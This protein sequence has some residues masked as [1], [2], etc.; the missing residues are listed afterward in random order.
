ML[1]L[2]E[3]VVFHFEIRSNNKIDSK[4]CIAIHHIEVEV[5][6]YDAK[7]NHFKVVDLQARL[8]NINRVQ[9]RKENDM[10]TIKPIEGRTVRISLGL[11]L[12]I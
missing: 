12:T 10:A 8:P 7:T 3:H 4:I 5:T 11:Q 1:L 6:F 2:F 9:Q